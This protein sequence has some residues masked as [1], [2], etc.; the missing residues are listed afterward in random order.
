MAL[1]LE[2]EQRLSKVGLIDFLKAKPDPWTKLVKQ[3]YDFVKANFPA[4]AV[5]RQDD[6]AKAL[7]PLLEVHSDLVDHLAAKKL[8]EKFWIKDFGYLILD[9]NWPNV[10]RST[11]VTKSK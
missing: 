4:D 3:T 11:N 2:A 9:R 5:I 8:R 7:I 1:T 6:V 10:T